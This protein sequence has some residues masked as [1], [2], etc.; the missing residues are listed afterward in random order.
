MFVALLSAMHRNADIEEALET[1]AAMRAE[2]AMLHAFKGMNLSVQDALQLLKNRRD[3]TLT[4][5]DK[6]KRD[7]LVSAVDNLVEFAVCQEY[8][9]YRKLPATVNLD[10]QEEQAD[11]DEL[12]EQYN[13]TYAAVENYDIEY[14]MGIAL[15]WIHY[16][17]NTIIT[18]N[19]QR[20]DRVR[21]WHAQF[22]GYYETR[23]KFPEWL[24]P[25]IEWACRCYLTDSDGDN[26][27]NALHAKTPKKP[28]QLDGVF[29]ES[30]AKC[31]RIFGKAHPYF[32]VRKEDKKML[33]GMVKRIKQK[34]YG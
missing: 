8:Q 31:G 4:Q 16:T 32:K 33:Q 26:I 24:I 20:D 2:I 6:D 17:E 5:E 30:V 13:K 10:D 7:R 11:Y 28:K 29:S 1:L 23:D 3:N 27:K 9:L 21:P 12:C 14:A 34:Y 15:A 18:Y 19:T 25:P 22:D